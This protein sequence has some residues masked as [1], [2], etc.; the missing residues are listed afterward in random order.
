MQKKE[1]KE[2]QNCKRKLE[3]INTK[4]NTIQK[5]TDTESHI[6]AHVYNKLDKL[7]KQRNCLELSN[8]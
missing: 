7:R 1:K 6:S 2:K 5:I 3:K 4:I 8:T